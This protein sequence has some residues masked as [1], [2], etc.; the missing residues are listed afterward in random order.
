M[1]YIS[2]IFIPD[3]DKNSSLKTVGRLKV[4]VSRVGPRISPPVDNK[5]AVRS[6]QFGVWMSVSLRAAQGHCP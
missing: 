6:L 3:P 1:R 4:E 2:E 5:G